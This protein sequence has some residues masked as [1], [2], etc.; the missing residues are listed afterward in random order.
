MGRV[1]Y[2]MFWEWNYDKEEKWLNE[3]AAKGL[4]LTWASFGRYKFED[5]EPGEYKIC[6]QLLESNKEKN[7]KYIEFLKE[8]GVEHVGICVD[9]YYFR[10]RATEEDFQLFSDH[11]SLINNLTKIIHYTVAL[12]VL[13][14]FIGCFN[15]FLCFDL[16][17]PINIFGILNIL[18]FVC[19]MIG[20]I[21]TF[22]KR[23]KLKM[24]QQIFE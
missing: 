18:I 11:A 21:R 19:G 17:S 2:K 14:L 13:N 12:L 8:T 20:L 7:A 4:A 24:E 5:C 3:M 15:I 6:M 22:Q 16:Q 10:K 9:W 1:I 23:K